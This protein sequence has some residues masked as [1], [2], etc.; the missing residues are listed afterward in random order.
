MQPCGRFLLWLWRFHVF[1]RAFLCRVRVWLCVD[2]LLALCE[3]NTTELCLLHVMQDVGE[4]A[5]VGYS[6][7][8][9]GAR[10][11]DDL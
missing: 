3:R 1:Y 7:V 4:H 10:R 5:Q 11:R 6:N 9:G 8:V 2:S